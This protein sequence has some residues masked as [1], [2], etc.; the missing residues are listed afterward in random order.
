MTPRRAL[1]ELRGLPVSGDQLPG[2]DFRYPATDGGKAEMSFSFGLSR[3][4]FK[5][6]TRALR[7]V[8]HTGGP[9]YSLS[10]QDC[11]P[12]KDGDFSVLGGPVRARDSKRVILVKGKHCSAIRGAERPAR[13]SGVGSA[14]TFSECLRSARG[15]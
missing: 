8:R 2:L 14:E 1:P 3:G 13:L 5:I 12:V 6:A 15:A 11:L 10:E 7:G 9:A 4:A